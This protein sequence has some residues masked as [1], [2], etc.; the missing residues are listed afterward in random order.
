MYVKRDLKEHFSSVSESYNMIAVVGARQAGKTTFLKEQ[1]KKYDSSYV[2]FDD[3]DARALFDEDV[4]KFEM[5]YIEGHELSVLDEVQHCRDSGSKLKYL[6]DTGRKLWI[7]S[8]S[9]ILMSKE[10]LFYLVGRVSIVR[11]YPFSHSEFIK[12]KKQK[13]TTITISKRMVWEHMTYGGYPKVVLTKDPNMK[14]I[15][16]R[17]LYETMILKDVARTFSISDMN[18]LEQ[19]SRYLAINTANLISYDNTT[20]TLGIT[21]PTL[22]KYL[23]AMEK[24][25]FI[26]RVKPYFTNKNKEL[27]KQPKIYFLD[28]G[29]RNIIID[30]FPVKPD[31]KVFENYVFSE[32][33]KA[34]YIPKYWRTKSKVEVDFVLEHKKD[35]IPIEVKV[36]EGSYS[37]DKSLHSFIN[38]YKPKKAYIVFYEGKKG[39]KKVNGCKV[40]FVDMAGLNSALGKIR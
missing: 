19:L 5:Q 38:N 6:V 32:V 39:T 3:P 33:I 9:E 4:K 24:S 37:I 36:S 27:T 23:D 18:A 8:S 1:M 7:T 31:G 15:I 16:L 29:L 35:V 40:S 11:L 21:F 17:D 14:K 2:L 20:K 12:A 10:I 34:G 28:C 30:D 25:Y 22:K 13:A 26:V